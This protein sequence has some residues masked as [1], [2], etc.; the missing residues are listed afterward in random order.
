MITPIH[1]KPEWYFLFAYAILRSIPNKIGGVIA[2]LIRILLLLIK[3]FQKFKFKLK[4]NFK[5]K[6]INF[7]FFY[8]FLILTYLGGQAVDYPFN[9]IS[10]IF[11]FLYFILVLLI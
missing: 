4:F 9:L 3:S 1:I 5:K 8:N 11:R 6:V 10:I 2:L 7:L